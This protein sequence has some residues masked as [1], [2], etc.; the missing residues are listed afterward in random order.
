MPP[1]ADQACMISVIVPKQ[2]QLKGEPRGVIV[3]VVVVVVVGHGALFCRG[4]FPI[5]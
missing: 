1:S 5:F 2:A 3:V 4:L